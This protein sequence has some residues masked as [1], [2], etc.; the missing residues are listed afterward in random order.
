[1]EK[2][3]FYV[4][5]VIGLTTW[6]SKILAAVP[7]ITYTPSTNTYTVSTTITTLT[8][9]NSG[10]AVAA[11]AY[12]AATALTGATLSNPHGVA[13]DASGNVY[14]TNSGNNT[15]SEYG[16]TGT[17]IGTFGSGA[18]MSFPKS[19]VF[20]SSGNAYVLNLGA[21]AGTGTVYKYNSSG[22][23]QSTILSGLNYALG[24]TIDASNNIYITDQGAVT[25]KKYSTSGTLLLSLPTTNLSTPLGVAVDASGNIYVLNNG[26]G[27][28]TKYNSAGTYQSVFLS[29]YTS[30]QSITID[31]SGNF[32][33]GDDPATNTVYV[34]NQSGTLLTSKAVTDPEGIAVD[35]KGDMFVSSYWANGMSEFKPSGGYY[36]NKNLPAGLSFNSSTGA[37]SGTPTAVSAS[38]VYTVTAYNASGSGSTTVTITV[39]NLTYGNY[40]FG[41]TI[42]LNTTSLGITSNLTNFPALLSIQD[43]NLIISNTCTDKVYNPNG[44][45]YDFAFVSGGSELYYQVESYNQTTGTLL[46]WV[47]IPSLTYATNNTITFF[48]GSKSPTVTHNT[49]F[50]QNTWAS[51]YLA[52]FH[53]NESSYTGSVTD[54]TSGG[55]TGTTSGMT[56]ADL[57]TGKIGTAYSFNGSSKKITTNAVSVTGTFTLSAWV[58]LGA[59]GLDQKVITNQSAGGGTSGGYK[60]GVYTTNIPESESGI[61]ANRLSTPN[62]TAFASGAW[63]YIQSVYTG[64]SLSTYV[65]GAQYKILITLNNPSA[66]PNLYIGVGEGGTTF[67]FNGTIDEPRVSNV[68]K[69]ADWIKAEY[70]DQNS[71]TTFTTVGSTVTTAANAAVVSGALTYTWTGSTSTDPTVASNWN[72][73][74]AGTTAQLP[75]F[76]GTATLVIPTGLTNYP[77]LT[78]DES[79]YGLTI[80]SGASLN[81]NGHTLSVGCNI[82][83]SSGGQI[84]YGSSN[85]SGI[86]WNGSA[87][88]QT[89]TGSSTSN[90]AQLGNMTVNNSAAGTVTISGGPVDIYNTLTLTNGSLTIAAS[91]AALTLKSTS[92]LTASVAAIPSGSVISG[93]VT[94]ERYIT[95]GSG[96]RTYRLLSSP[97][98]TATISSTYNVYSLNYL[99]NSIWLTGSSG[100]G[101][102]KTGNPT[103][104][105]YREDQIPSN[106]TFTSGNFWGISAINNSPTYNYYL[107][108]GATVYNI[109]VGNGIMFFFR[110]NKASASLA[111]ETQPSY[112]T[113]VTVTLST[114]GSLTQG[115]VVVRDWY[116]PASTNIGYTGSGSGAGT[117]STVRGFNLVGNP[118]AS[119]IDWSKFSNSSSAAAIYGVNVGPTIWTFDPST[120]NYAT[121]NALTNIST[122]NGGKII[123]SGQGFFVQATTATPTAPSLT[124][125][126]AAKTSTQ[127]TAGSTLL[128]STHSTLATLQQ[129]AYNSYL[130]LKMVTDS[131]NYSDV[132]IG[133]N[134]TSNTKFNPLEDSRFVWGMGTPESVAAVSA[135]S[136]NTSAKWVPFP[137]SNLSQVVK[138]YVWAQ[139]NGTYKFNRT[140]FETIPAIYEVWLM[141]GYKKDSL[142]LRN[143]TTYAFDVNLADTASFGNNRFTVVIRQNPALGVHLLNFAAAKVVNGAQCIWVT[144]NEANYTNFT[145]ERSTDN[146]KT[147]NVLGGFASDDLGTYSFLDKTPAAVNQYRLKLEDLNGA[148]TYSNIVTLM[149][150]NTNNTLAKSAISVYPNPAKGVLNLTINPGF[151]PTSA[152]PGTGPGSL[153]GPNA[154]YTIKIVNIT[155]SVI[156][157]ASTELQDWQTDVSDLMPGTYVIQ[158]SNNGSNQLV[159]RTT[160]V[161]L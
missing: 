14:V 47:Q 3:L 65:D 35:S 38:T 110:G 94:A 106:A 30:A 19:I 52:V 154:L 53:F 150:A 61:A 116:T 132:V 131:V 44:P 69:S 140:D 10:G 103:L 134:S 156:K 135:D 97:V 146:G 4:F 115:Q 36:L 160:F 82:Y 39:N 102:D 91:P 88:T 46:V 28:V 92:S 138:L 49:A 29:G 43:N 155:G 66:N 60:L 41:E 21:T 158:V 86:T 109:P 85:T 149:Y 87:A 159:G 74:T 83:N 15:I 31:G 54:G 84:L 104:Y 96:Y 22:V 125:Q 80:A 2:R 147:F 101:F 127:P 148:I 151:S 20:D 13:I 99:Q 152:N 108:N 113:P 161:K 68:A 25:V 27:N 32:Y 45:N 67:Y 123:A 93:N 89:Y 76:D 114:S 63:H 105:L 33:I 144:E 1:M 136:I 11:F 18:T 70:G 51:D 126:E 79:L 12:G 157:N 119:S 107:N 42:T 121:Y 56:S 122:G 81:L 8:P 143:N 141:D 16:P 77:S 26:T 64:T 23:Y 6:S 9:G 133:F 124:F 58:K 129:S 139:A 120:K 145:I 78:A 142:D 48:Y 7:V 112:T 98:Y 117:N 90:T 5:L 75:A 59:T 72:N 137:K 100:G 130:R 17:Y 128:M 62:P 95:G 118:Y 111:T 24:M 37:I 153:L 73:T 40:G 55:H 34:Y 71:P 57:V 50:F